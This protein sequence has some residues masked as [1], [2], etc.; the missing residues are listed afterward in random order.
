MKPELEALIRALDAVH[1]ARSGMETR[2]REAIYQSM[3]DDLQERVPNVARERLLNM[4]A[5]KH[6][7]CAKKQDR[8]PTLPPKA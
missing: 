1:S 2:Q 7:R 3:V 5:A 4:I 6:D 8:F